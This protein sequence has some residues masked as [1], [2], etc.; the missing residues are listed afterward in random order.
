MYTSPDINRRICPSCDNDY[1]DGDTHVCPDDTENT[2]GG[3]GGSFF[4]WDTLIIISAVIFL[5]IPYIIFKGIEWCLLHLYLIL[6]AC[7]SL[8]ILFLAGVVIAAYWTK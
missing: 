3:Y 4:C 7:V 6:I 1:E 5:G 2:G 8:S